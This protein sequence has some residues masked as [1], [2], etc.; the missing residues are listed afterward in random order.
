MAFVIQEAVLHC[1]LLVYAVA[2]SSKFG[3]ILVMKVLGFVC[4]ALVILSAGIINPSHPAPISPSSIISPFR[5][6][7][8]ALRLPDEEEEEGPSLGP[9]GRGGGG[10][11]EQAHIG[12]GQ[13]AAEAG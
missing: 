3:G 8:P 10:E 4:F 11:E 2:F 7:S 6:V 12:Q 13:A 9:A 5:S 1:G